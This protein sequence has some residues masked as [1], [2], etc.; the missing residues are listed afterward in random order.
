[1]VKKLLQYVLRLYAVRA[2]V[3]VGERV[4][5]GLWSKLWAPQKL[6][7]EDDV[8]IGSGCTIEVDGRIGRWS[9]LANGVGLV[10]RHDHDFRCVGKPVRY[11]PWI[12]DA[13]SRFRGPEA[14]VTVE[15][16]VWIGYGAI[17][18]SGVTIGRG[19]IVAAGSVVPKTVERYAIVAGAPARQVGMRFTPDE[20]REHEAK[21]GYPPAVIGPVGTRSV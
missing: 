21:L 17:V 11:A 19:A 20:I 2:R 10:G 18:L 4:Q 1:M 9:M 8:Y 5:I 6:V 7:V 14:A 15:E 12:G 13:D 3:Q 16:D